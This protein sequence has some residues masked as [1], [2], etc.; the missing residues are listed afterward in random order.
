MRISIDPSRCIAA[1]QCVLKAAKVF[2]QNESDGT[3]MLLL[4]RPPAELQ[5]AAR[6][7][8]RVCPSEAITIHET[9]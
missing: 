1:G 4:E 2:D 8:A 6:L 5:D 7:A 9:E 3:V